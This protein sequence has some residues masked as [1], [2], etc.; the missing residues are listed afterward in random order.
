MTVR[1][2]LFRVAVA[3]LTSFSMPGHM[4]RIFPLVLCLFLLHA[5]SSF[6]QI[7][8]DADDHSKRLNI[9]VFSQEKNTTMAGFSIRANTWLAG[10]FSKRLH[11]IRISGPAELSAKLDALMARFPG[12]LIG[13]LWIDSHG[14]FR[15]GRSL[16]LLGYD[17]VDH[18][19]ADSPPVRMAL[20]AMSRYCDEHS[21]VTIGSCY[22][23]ADYLRPA[24]QYLPA[25]PMKGDSLMLSVAKSFP[26]TPI[27][28]AESWVMTKPFMF[29]SRSGINGFPLARHYRDT[30]FRPV[31]ERLGQWK[32]LSP[33]GSKPEPAGSISLSGSGDIRFNAVGYLQNNGARHRQRKH[34]S[35]L[36]PDLYG[37][38]HPK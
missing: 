1:S 24:N 29:G 16:F 38:S 33:G 17:T 8:M 13:N 36:E 34:L 12:H 23:S 27:L 20:A 28:A 11:A 3:S 26:R 9:F 4:F 14:S 19:L 31:W 6:S 5:G 37:D 22:G 2:E 35:H 21:I 32:M 10:L 7:H 25:S 18:L 15:A 30:I